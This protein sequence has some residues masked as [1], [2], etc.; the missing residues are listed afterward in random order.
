MIEEELMM[1]HGNH[2]AIYRSRNKHEETTNHKTT[3]LITEFGNLAYV[4]KPL[5]QWVRIYYLCSKLQNYI[6]NVP[7]GLQTNLVLFCQI[8]RTQ[9]NRRR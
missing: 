3:K 6:I 4:S 7:N 1:K 5:S 9:Q 8:S 2:K